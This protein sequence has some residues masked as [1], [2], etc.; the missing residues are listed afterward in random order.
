MGRTY[1]RD[2]I[3]AAFEKWIT[4]TNE[5]QPNATD[6]DECTAILCG[7]MDAAQQPEPT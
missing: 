4:S 2:E 5:E 1:T 7:Y 6:P 3:R